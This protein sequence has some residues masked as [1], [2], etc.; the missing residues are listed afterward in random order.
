[1]SPQQIG[2]DLVELIRRTG[3]EVGSDLAA[4][5]AAR[6]SHLATMVGSPDFFEALAVERDNVSLRAGV[7]AVHAGDAID[8]KIVGLIEAALAIGARAML[9]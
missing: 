9:A 1:V 5:A 7:L 2:A 8:R 6:T 4:Y 3:R